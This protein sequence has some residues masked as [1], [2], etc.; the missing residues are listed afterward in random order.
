MF[1]KKLEEWAFS[2]VLVVLVIGR[3]LLKFV[4]Q[5]EIERISLSLRKSSENLI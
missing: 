1:E 4:R 5:E 3:S 2:T